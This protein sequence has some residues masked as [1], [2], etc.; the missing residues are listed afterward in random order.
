MLH[1]DTPGICDDDVRIFHSFTRIGTPPY[2]FVASEL[3]YTVPHSL[4]CPVSL[5]TRDT[6]LVSKP[7]IG[8][9]HV[10]QDVRGIANVTNS[11]AGGWEFG[12]GSPVFLNSRVGFL[13]WDWSG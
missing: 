8:D 1:N 2:V 7:R 13:L 11:Q 4:G 9:K 12:Q 5:R 3:F 6:E 10:M